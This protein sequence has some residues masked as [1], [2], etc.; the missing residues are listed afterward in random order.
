MNLVIMQLSMK[1]PCSIIYMCTSDS[2]CKTLIDG[3]YIFTIGNLRISSAKACMC[4]YVCMYAYVLHN[5]I[6]EIL[7]CVCGFVVGGQHTVL[8]P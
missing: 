8:E 2:D 7:F 3:L 5:S 1:I 6:T 4:M